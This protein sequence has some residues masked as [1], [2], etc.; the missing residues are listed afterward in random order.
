MAMTP[1]LPAP[2]QSARLNSHS[3][4]DMKLLDAAKKL[5]ATFLA[6]MLKSAGLCSGS[7]KVA[8]VASMP[9][10]AFNAAAIAPCMPSG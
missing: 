6:E 5:E 2:H 7:C 4:T 10:A 3:T 1:V 8:V 9:P